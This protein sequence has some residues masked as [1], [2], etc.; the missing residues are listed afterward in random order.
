MMLLSARPFQHKQALVDFER[1]LPLEVAGVSPLLLATAC[2][3]RYQ[4]S[5]HV[6]EHQHAHLQPNS[7]KVAEDMT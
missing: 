5:T 6:P 2:L 1:L 7:S 4:H 3:R